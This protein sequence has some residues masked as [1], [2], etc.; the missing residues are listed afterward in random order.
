MQINDYLQQANNFES[1]KTHDIKSQMKIMSIFSMVLNVLLVFLMFIILPFKELIPYVIQVDKST[2]NQ[3]V[4]TSLTQK[5][6]LHL[7]RKINLILLVILDLKDEIP[8]III[9]L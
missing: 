2:G 7:K 3:S 8:F 1:S 4:L 9:Y 6:T 5:N